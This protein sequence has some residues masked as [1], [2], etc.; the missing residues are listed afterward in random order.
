[1]FKWFKF[2]LNCSWGIC[3]KVDRLPTTQLNETCTYYMNVCYAIIFPVLSTS[4]WKSSQHIKTS[5]FFFW[6]S[7]NCPDLYAPLHTALLVNTFFHCCTT[8][9]P[10]LF[11]TRNSAANN[12]QHWAQFFYIAH[13]CQ[14]AFGLK[15]RSHQEASHQARLIQRLGS[16]SVWKY[17]H[18]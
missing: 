9:V 11:C 12:L 13:Q 2:A 5:L 7:F 15:G 8:A 10:F 18:Y 14:C 1:M 6:Q 16:A 4:T 3:T 17:S